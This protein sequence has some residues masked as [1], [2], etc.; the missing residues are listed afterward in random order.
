MDHQ[1]L[2]HG[3]GQRLVALAQVAV[4]LH[5][6]PLGIDRDQHATGVDH[7]RRFST[8]G[9][10]GPPQEIGG[11]LVVVGLD[12]IGAVERRVPTRTGRVP[13]GG[14]GGAGRQPA[15]ARGGTGSLAEPRD[16]AGP[17]D[18]L[19]LA[20]DRRGQPHPDRRPVVDEADRRRV[21]QPPALVSPVEQR[22]QVAI[23]PISLPV[24]QALNVEQRAD[25]DVQQQ[26][27]QS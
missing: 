19:G 14:C 4:D 12:D 6:Q 11:H 17:R 10:D 26:D 18:L 25:E 7:A 15:P 1:G 27:D 8:D 20:G 13:R 5:E 9:P 2:A 3:L 22:R 16:D 21:R 24:I 23:G